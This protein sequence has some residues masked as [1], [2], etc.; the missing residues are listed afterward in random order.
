MV[1]TN[2]K[3][4]ITSKLS[5]LIILNIYNSKKKFSEEIDSL[6]ISEIHYLLSTI[7]YQ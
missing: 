7:K 6:I 2:I 1:V 5:K 4:L 3:F